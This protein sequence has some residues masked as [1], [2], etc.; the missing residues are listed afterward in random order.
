MASSLS[1][2]LIKATGGAC[3]QLPE[4]AAAAVIMNI[5]IITNAQITV[6]LNIIT[7]LQKHIHTKLQ[8]LI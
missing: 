8:G 3:S 5:I 4:C 6:M 2:R 7:M 1:F